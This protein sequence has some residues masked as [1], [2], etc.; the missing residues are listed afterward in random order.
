MKKILN[1]LFLTLL[2][3]FTF[4]SCS[5]V[6]SPYDILGEGDVPGLTGEGTKDSP[7]T[8]SDLKKK[9]DNTTVAWV[10]AYIV[11]GVKSETSMSISSAADVV[12][13]KQP[14][15]VKATVILIADNSAESD[16]TNCSAVN[17]NGSAE[18]A[19]AVKAALNLVDNKA[20]ELPRLVTLKGTLVKNT[21]GLAGLKEVTAVMLEDGTII[22]EGG[23]EGPTDENNPFGLDAS[24]PLNEINADFEEQPDFVQEGTFTS[25]LNYDYSLAGWKNV[26]FVG[27]RKWT[28]VVFKDNTKYIQASAN[29]GSAPTYTSWFVSP[30]F[31]V[32][33]IKDKTIEFDCAGAYFYATTTLKVYFL[34]LVNG[35]MQKTEIPVTGIPISGDNYVWVKGIK[36]DLKDQSGK[37]GFIGFEYVAEGGASKSTTYQIDNIKSGKSEGGG[38][39]PGPDPVGNGTKENPYDVTTAL[40]LSSATGTTVAWVKGYIVGGVNTDG[41]SSSVNGPEDIIFGVEGIRPAAIVIAGSANE[42]DY[43][44]CLVIGFGNDSQA[45]KTALNLVDHPENLGKEVL[46]Q[47]TLKHAFSAPGMKTITDHELVGGG[48]VP[49]PSTG[50]IFI[51]EYVEGS[52]NNKYI[53][54]YNPTGQTIDLAG[55]SLDVA[56]N[57]GDWSANGTYNNSMDLTGK[58]IASRATLVFKHKQATIYAGEAIEANFVNFNGDDA[59]GLFK[60]GVLIDIVGEKGNA[61]KYGVDVTLRR[62]AS[63]KG[64]NSVYT[65]DEWEKLEKDNV[66][67]LG[68]H[69]MN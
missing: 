28:G 2:A 43:T 46:L 60:N 66:S 7:Y 9:A 48:E 1:A 34:E 36:I 8:I 16:Y 38:E 14:T 68:S 6:P 51:S 10:Q 23:S 22:G 59:V 69:T 44:K 3:V 5:D 58:T 62:K 4:S 27:D 54:I 55:Y 32:D 30:A 65:V 45:A 39:T 50:E 61:A 57:G 56:A 41:G 33:N 17:L 19:S 67:D 29:K 52:S 20:I 49:E 18:G 40:S 31:T 21:W 24:N 12:F 26:A 25:N 11:A 15:G 37:I 42:T 64:P 13:G 47:G 63:V 53:E 35:V